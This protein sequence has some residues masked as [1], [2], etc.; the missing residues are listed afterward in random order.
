MDI[1][2]GSEED[3]LSTKKMI[4]VVEMD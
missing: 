4:E 3:S 2:E 1:V